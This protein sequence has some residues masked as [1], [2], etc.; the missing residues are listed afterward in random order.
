M[1][2]GDSLSGV[3][4]ESGIGAQMPVP[5]QTRA[6]VCEYEERADGELRSVT[7]Q[8]SE[9]DGEPQVSPATPLGGPS[10]AGK[11]PAIRTIPT[12]VSDPYN[13][14]VSGAALAAPTG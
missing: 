5:G 1:T 14:A 6:G 9:R 8:L 11:I 4:P 3:L 7:P 2:P 10:R 12:R 13:L